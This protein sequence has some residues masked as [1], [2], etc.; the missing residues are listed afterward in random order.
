LSEHI[1]STFL[2]ALVD[3][4]LTGEPLAQV[5][6]HLA[7][8]PQCTGSA[9]QQSL[10]KAATARAGQRYTPSPDLQ[11]RIMRLAATQQPH[12]HAPERRRILTPVWLAAAALLLVGIGLFA[13]RHNLSRDSFGAKESAALATEV[14]DQ[15]IAMLAANA[16]PQV[17]SSDRHTVKPWFQG[18]L[19]F[20]FNL[21][22]NLPPDVT[23]DGANLTYLHNQP[24]AQ[25][26]YSVGKHHV[27][28]FLL[29]PADRTDRKNSVSE[30]SGFNLI[31]TATGNLDV[32][33]VSDVD[34][35]RLADLTQRIEQAQVAPH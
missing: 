31:E 28:V 2:N 4:E 5:N 24:A 6:E 11:S 12:T 7:A 16:T 18:K 23:L 10:L 32:I 15:H 8:C 27:S 22:Q 13:L 19:P 17:I 33:S 1:S 9:L 25:L 26:L 3:G 14:S 21:P 20:S 29:Q 30:H 35:A 34:P